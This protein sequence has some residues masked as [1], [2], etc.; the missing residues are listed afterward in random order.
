MAWGDA[1]PICRRID[2]HRA[3]GAGHVCIQALN[4]NEARPALPDKQILAALAPKAQ[5]SP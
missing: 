2:E 1:A 4:P 3:A 5:P